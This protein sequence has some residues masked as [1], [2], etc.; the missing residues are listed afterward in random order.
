VLWDIVRVLFF[1]GG[2]LGVE[3]ST[4]TLNRYIC[5]HGD[6]R[7]TTLHSYTTTHTQHHARSQG[8]P[9]CCVYSTRF[10]AVTFV[11]V[12]LCDWQARGPRAATDMS[13]QAKSVTT[14]IMCCM[15]AAAVASWT[16]FSCVRAHGGIRAPLAALGTWCALP[17]V[18]VWVLPGPRVCKS[19][20]S[21]WSS[22]TT[23]F[24][25]MRHR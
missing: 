19:L 20:F 24:V 12:V 9:W 22:M 11:C 5:T 1:R 18:C 16:R 13:M 3:I 14:T 4:H 15:T 6:A 7:T 21:S 23:V 2:E 10:E 25:V 8:V 17:F